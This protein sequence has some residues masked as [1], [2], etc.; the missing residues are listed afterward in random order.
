MIT[1]LGDAPT[2]R[3]RKV[4]YYAGDWEAVLSVLPQ[5]ELA[6]FTAGKDEPSNPFLKTVLRKPLLTT[7][8]PIPVGVVS[9]AYSLVNHAEAAKLCRD[10]L[11]EAGANVDGLRYEVGLSELGEWMNLRIYL[12]E[13]YS[14]GK[15]WG[16]KMDLRVECYNSVD[17][18]SRLV[19]QFGWRR[20]ACLN[21]LV[22][23]ESKIEI[24]E[25]HGEGLDLKDISGRLLPAFEAVEVDRERM[26]EWHSEKIQAHDVK[27]WA[28]TAVTKSWGK[29]AAARVFHICDTGKDVEFKDP[30]SPGPATEKPVSYVGRVP[31]SPDRADTK[32][33]VAQT[34]SFVA[35]H[36]N[37][38][39][40]RVAR[41]LEIP[42]LLQSLNRSPLA[43]Q[44]LLSL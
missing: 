39:E 14:F 25:R 27:E 33:D 1:I 3:S 16:D 26:E 30:F 44:R 35:S 17:G 40:E 11:V 12:P 21:G 7:E 37:N 29:K 32:Y 28:D 8:R 19:I 18:T 31:G 15:K 5:F 20:L 9:H 22:I 42:Q 38:V 41:Q 6:P 24:N 36:R 4:R 10:G 2:W 13:D 23:S 34:L 43:A